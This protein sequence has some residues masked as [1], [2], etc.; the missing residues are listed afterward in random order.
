MSNN[1][2]SNTLHNNSQDN[3]SNDTQNTPN[4]TPLNSNNIPIPFQSSTN[5][6]SQ[7]NR[8]NTQDGRTLA[9]DG[10]SMRRRSSINETPV[11]QFRNVDDQV[12]QGSIS[13]RRRRVLNESIDT[14]HDTQYTQY[15]K[16]PMVIRRIRAARGDIGDMGREFLMQ[17]FEIERLPYIVDEEIDQVYERFTN[18]FYDFNP[19]NYPDILTDLDNEI[20]I[21]SSTNEIQELSYYAKKLLKIVEMTSEK[22]FP[23]DLAHIA[24]FDRKL[25]HLIVNYPADC[26]C[27]IDKIVRKCFE[28]LTTLVFNITESAIIPRIVLYNKPEFDT[29]RLLGPKDI[30]TLVSLKG[31]V[32]RFS[33]VIPE[34]TMAAFRCN[35][36]KQSGLNRVTCNNEIYEHVIQGDVIEPML[37]K[38]CGSRNSFELVHNMCCFTSKQLIKLI[39]LPE[40]LGKGQFPAS[41]SL[42]AY[43]ECIDAAKPGD[44][45]E[46]TGIFRASGVRMNPRM[47]N[48]STIFKTFI[49]VLHIRKID[50]NS[51]K[52]PQMGIFDSTEEGKAEHLHLSPEL[53]S[54]ILNLSRDKN[55]YEKL[56]K[57]FAPSIYGRDDVKMGLLCQLFGGS[58][59]DNTRSDI[60]ILL[61]GDPSTAKSQFLQY[62]HKLSLR[63]IYTSGKG[64]SQV[65]LTAYVGKDPETR[66][67]ILESGAVVLSDRGICC[68]DEFDKMNESARTVLHEVSNSL[69][70]LW[71]NRRSLLPKPE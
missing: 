71:N 53:I 60:H 9:F 47:R 46:I 24:L 19:L 17:D 57:S 61:C 4:G 34:M 43:D 58:K 69:S 31:I 14:Q 38:N 26:I 2:S 56:I 68:I 52:V 23:V 39:E 15:G 37:C 20:I 54:Q 8:N 27:E 49:N 1:R 5:T 67:Y 18:F 21:N 66:E 59:N 36:Y 29:S 22:T 50:K 33:N 25:Y 48:L 10:H 13:M 42:Y 44:R 12:D 51:V 62:V 32:V 7:S 70:R 30:E 6:G 64:S 63:G 40:V 65:G 28:K 45:V 41:I 55:I 3:F 16:T 35:G 11:R